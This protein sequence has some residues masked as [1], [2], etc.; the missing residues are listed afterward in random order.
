MSGQ[1][2]GAVE[3]SAYVGQSVEGVP[4]FNGCGGIG[5]SAMGAEGTKWTCQGENRSQ[6]ESIFEQ[7]FS[8]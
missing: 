5:A 6:S 2:H 7:F 1:E 8:L 3:D 4:P